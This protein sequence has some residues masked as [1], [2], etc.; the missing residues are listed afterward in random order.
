MKI[1]LTSLLD[2]LAEARNLPKEGVGS[3]YLTNMPQHG[4]YAVWEVTTESGGVDSWNQPRIKP[5]Q[6]E[7]FLIRLI[8]QEANK[9][10]N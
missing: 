7:A 8:N 9:K 5:R 3:V 1:K 10:Q 2:K 4:G 6:M